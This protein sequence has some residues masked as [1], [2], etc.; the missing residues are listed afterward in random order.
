MHISSIRLVN[1][2]NFADVSVSLREFNVIIGANAS[3]KSNLVTVV[4]FLKDAATHGIDNAIS[5]QG[6]F[7]YLRTIGCDPDS[8]VV[9]GITLRDLGTISIPDKGIGIRISTLSYELR[10]GLGDSEQEYSVSERAEIQCDLFTEMP[11]GSEDTPVEELAKGTVVV[12][13]DRGHISSEVPQELRAVFESKGLK[14]LV[15]REP[16][17][18][19]LGWRKFSI[20]EHTAL[21]S[22]LLIPFDQFFRSTATFDIDS[23]TCKRTASA[24]GMAELEPDGRNLAIRLKQI[25][26]DP[27]QKKRLIFLI[28]DVLPFIRNVSVENLPDGTLLTMME[29]S[30]FDGHTLPSFL[31]SDGTVAITA[32]IVALYFERKKVLFFEEPERNIH[33][34]LIGNI[35]R[36]MQDVTS[37]RHYQIIVTTHNPEFVRY[38]PLENLLLVRRNEEGFSTVER[39]ADSEDVRMF[40]NEDLGVEDLY[41]Q[42]LLE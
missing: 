19:E 22:P 4:K 38:T 28:G 15:L 41:V 17:S 16:L 39:P 11:F 2:K 37:R 7:S 42:G 27:R 5:I 21:F 40:L 6:G 14:E 29:E 25:V 3:G 8:E 24:T 9:I 10:L 30:Y 23:H 1:F 13:N 12:S 31:L 32:M 34:A 36:F 26:S 35:V 33:P 20:I 18:E